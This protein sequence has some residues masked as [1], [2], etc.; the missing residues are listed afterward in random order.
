MVDV[1]AD[2]GPDIDPDIDPD[3]ALNGGSMFWSMSK[4]PCYTC[5]YSRPSPLG[6]ACVP[7]L[8][9]LGVGGLNGSEPKLAVFE[10][11]LSYVHLLEM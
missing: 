4:P 2:V 8:V 5:G 3:I 1:A 11:I 7:K 6:L 10:L 9:S